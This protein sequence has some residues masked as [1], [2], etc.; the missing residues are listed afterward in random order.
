MVRRS[1]G[2]NK[3]HP[4]RLRERRGGRR[5]PRARRGES[6]DTRCELYTRVLALSLPLFSVRAVAE[7]HA[8]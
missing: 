2:S 3:V 7:R 6:G 8:L 5:R 1:T 4:K